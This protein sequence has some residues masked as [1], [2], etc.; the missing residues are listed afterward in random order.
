VLFVDDQD[1]QIDVGAGIE[2]APAI[3]A[4]GCQG[5]P[6]RHRQ[7]L[8]DIAQHAI[9]QRGTSAKQGGAVPFLAPGGGQL[10]LA[11]DQALAGGAPADSVSTSAPVSVTS[12]VCSHW[13]DRLRSLV[14]MVQPSGSSE[15]AALPALIIGS[16]VKI[17]P[18]TQQRSRVRFAVMQDL[19][20]LVELAADAVAAEFAD[21]RKAGAFGMALDGA[22]P[23]SPRCAHRA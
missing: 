1:Q 8:P 15:I 17:M 19:G 16:M 9:D 21:H 23:I 18:G 5:A 3:A 6:D 20:F 11:V 13:A 4:H 10:L 7:G 2:P 14:T 12:T 22:W